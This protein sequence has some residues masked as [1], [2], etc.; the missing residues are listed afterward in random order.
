M[1]PLVFRVLVF[2]IASAIS[3]TAQPAAMKELLP[4]AGTSFPGVE[5]HFVWV[6]TPMES[7]DS[8]HIRLLLTTHGAP[9]WTET[10]GESNAQIGRQVEELRA[11]AKQRGSSF[12]FLLYAAGGF[13]VDWTPGGAGFTLNG[14]HYEWPAGDSVLVFSLDRID[15]VGG[16]PGMRRAQ[17]AAP[18]ATRI[19]RKYFRE[20]VSG[21]VEALDADS[22]AAPLLWS[23]P[24][25]R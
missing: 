16:P 25:R 4:V 14:Q 2:L 6:A 19:P 10:D 3:A 15:G 17:V 20:T 7:S 9:G 5:G 1:N 23:S 13:V 12:A 8:V 11:N 21:A 22:T 18:F 24:E